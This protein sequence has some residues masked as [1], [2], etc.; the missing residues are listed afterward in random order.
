MDNAHQ[1]AEEF[2]AHTD[3]A[4]C[5]LLAI[6]CGSDGLE[7][8]VDDE[9]R[10]L[11]TTTEDMHESDDTYILLVNVSDFLSRWSNSYFHSPIHRVKRLRKHKEQDSRLSIAYFVGGVVDPSD[12]VACA[13]IL[14]PGEQPQ[15]EPVSIREYLEL[16][17]AS[18]L[19]THKRS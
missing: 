16:K 8:I 13:P 3:W 17:Y 18:T 6:G 14:S 15:F 2:P 10:S 7:V 12:D 1:A 11:R 9:W 5:T 19:G 4:A